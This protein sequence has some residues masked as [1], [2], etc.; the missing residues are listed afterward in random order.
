MVKLLRQV[1]FFFRSEELAVTAPQLFELVPPRPMKLAASVA[2]GAAPANR[3]FLGAGPRSA[4]A[5][6]KPGIRSLPLW[7]IAREKWP[8]P[9]ELPKVPAALRLNAVGSKL[10]MPVV[11]F[12]IRQE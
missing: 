12:R 4:R 2:A 8:P 9:R 6:M 3:T 7:P 11:V 10:V 5:G 1:W